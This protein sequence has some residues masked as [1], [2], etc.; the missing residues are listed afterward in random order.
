MLSSSVLAKAQLPTAQ[1]VASKMTVGCNLGNTLEAICGESAWGAGNTTQQLIDS[2]KAAGFNTVRLPVAWFCHS[3][4][5]T[6]EIDPLWIARVAEVVDYCIHDD[7]YVIINAHW[8]QGWL[9]NRVDA[10]NQAKVNERQYA[11][12]SQIAEYFKD[13]DEH[14]LFAGAN[15]PHAEDAQAMDVLLTYHQTFIDAVRKTGGNNGSRTLIIQGPSTDIDKTNKLMNT[16]P[17]DEIEN[18]L[19]VEVHY[20]TPYQ[21]CLMNGDANWG[22]MF[23]YWGNDNHSSTDL[24][25]N[26][27][28]G[29][30]AELDRLFG[31]M[32]TKFVDKGIP[33]IIGE[34]GAYKRKLNPP[35]DQELHNKSVDYFNKYV[36]KSAISKG[37]IPYYWDTPGGLFDRKN[38]KVLDRSL[39]NAMME[40]VAE[41][42]KT[43]SYVPFF[44]KSINL[45]P[46]PFTSTIH[47]NGDNINE[48]VNIKIFDRLGKQVEAVKGTEIN[49]SITMGASLK[50]DF[51]LIQ[52]SGTNWLKSFPTMKL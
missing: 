19:M 16:M 13:Y 29:E 1:Q 34:F 35:S 7:L 23:Y 38:G 26:S 25:R 3:D 24:T 22:K 5:I 20:Y 33:V 36:M 21:F 30:E 27:S 43:Q 31:L 39:L 37:M 52:I 6:S 51:Y 32:K 47:F 48:I 50:P 46:N 40:G 8:D 15:E 28:W 17:V 9:E 41:T 11:Y 18:R 2:I 45:Y 14:L 12:W 44:N 10:I 4:T 42:N 49:E